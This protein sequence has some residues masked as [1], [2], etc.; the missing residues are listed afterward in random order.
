MGSPASEQNQAE[1]DDQ[2]DESQVQVTLSKG[3]WLAKTELT[4]EQWE[5]LM[6]SNPSCFKGLGPRLPVENVSWHDALSFIRKA[7][8]SGVLPQG[9]KFALPTEAQWEYACRAGETGPYSGGSLGEVAWYGK[10]S[11]CRTHPVATKKSNA[12]GLHDM[13][14]N[15]LEWCADWYD[16]TLSGGTD[17]SGPSSGLDRVSRGGCYLSDAANCRAATRYL[18]SSSDQDSNLG[19][20]PAL[21][22]TA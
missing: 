13:H 2:F 19:F 14:G 9:W 1:D 11:Y 7:N 21:V 22:P 5:S 10:N 8:D 6:E 20:R 12:W 15:V 16:D 4:Q 17:P 3:F 18:R